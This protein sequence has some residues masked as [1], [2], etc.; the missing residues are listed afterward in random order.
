MSQFVIK[1]HARRGHFI[2]RGIGTDE[3]TQ[4]QRIDNQMAKDQA[5]YPST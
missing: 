4:G 1:R 2:N 5:T 3:R